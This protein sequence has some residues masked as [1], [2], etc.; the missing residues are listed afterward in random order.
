[1]AKAK[2]KK[3][4]GPKKVGLFDFLKRL[5]N[6]KSL[7]ETQEGEELDGFSPFMINRFMSCEMNFVQLS[8][9]MNTNGLTKEMVFDFYDHTIPKNNTFIKYNAKKEKAEKHLK[10]VMDWYTCNIQTAKQ[11]M[12]LISEDEMQEIIDFFEKRGRK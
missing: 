10:Y 4:S 8:N 3:E 12:R 9:A 5:V 7:P 11:Y 2:A 1:M 6:K